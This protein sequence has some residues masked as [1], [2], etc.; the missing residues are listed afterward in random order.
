MRNKNGATARVCVHE[1]LAVLKKRVTADLA[2]FVQSGLVLS[3][4]RIVA[5]ESALLDFKNVDDFG[6]RLIEFIETAAVEAERYSPGAFARV[7]ASVNNKASVD[8]WQAA[9]DNGA[10]RPTDKDIDWLIDEFGEGTPKDA[11]REV[12]DLVGFGGRVCVEQA[13]GQDVIVEQGNGFTFPVGTHDIFVGRYRNPRVFVV[14]GYI[15]SVA[16]VTTLLEQSHAS[17]EYLVIFHR[18]MHADVTNTLAVNWRRGTLRCIPVHVPFDVEGINTLNDIAVAC[19][20]DVTSSNKGELISTVDYASLVYV[21]EIIAWSNKLSIMNDSNVSRVAAHVQELNRRRCAINED[22]IKEL[23]DKRI[24][25]LSSNVVT[26]KLPVWSGYRYTRYRVDEFLR[27]YRCLV[28]HGTVVV[29]EKKH[30]ATTALAMV[31]YVP[32]LKRQLEELG[33]IISLS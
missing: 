32:V 30:L 29:N 15:E 3:L 23:Y 16:E 13:N 33:A 2:K 11:L 21:E 1:D 6:R 14:D 25:S 22:V 8:E 19:D 9:L 7:I 31:R 26:L 5:P 18:G 12:I 17:K 10:D 20:S 24:R 27:A 28:D 4:G